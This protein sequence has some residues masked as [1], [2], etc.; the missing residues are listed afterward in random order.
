MAIFGDGCAAA[1]IEK[2]TTGPTVAA[3]KV[4]QIEGTLDVVRMELSDQDSLPA[5]RSRSSR[6]RRSFTRAV[7][8]SST[9]SGLSRAQLARAQL[10]RPRCSRQCRHALDL[11]R[12][13]RDDPT[14]A[15]PAQGARSH[16]DRR[17]GSD[18]RAHAPRVLEHISPPTRNQVRA[19]QRQ[20]HSLDQ[21]VSELLARMAQQ[22][23][24][25]K[26][27]LQNAAKERT[28]QR[29]RPRRRHARIPYVSDSKTAGRRDGRA[30][31]LG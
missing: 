16:G 23:R 14:P 13:L 27:P 11:L 21:L 6:R 24:P 18:G 30:H 19:R 10:R 20:R 4:H 7:G 2:G 31:E 26:A 9:A 3:S 8:A 1:V 22:R 5:P 29:R 25:A 12:P 15:P 17:P 28:S